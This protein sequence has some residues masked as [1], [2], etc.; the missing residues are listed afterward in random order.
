MVVNLG[1][2]LSPTFPN[3]IMGKT[4]FI[5]GDQGLYWLV[6]FPTDFVPDPGYSP[7]VDPSDLRVDPRLGLFLARA[8]VQAPSS[9][10]AALGRCRVR[11]R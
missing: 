6:T 4:G 11:L 2:N 8:R 3:L 10:G 1:V 5:G 7:E 9:L